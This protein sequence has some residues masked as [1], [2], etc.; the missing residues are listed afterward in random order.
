MYSKRISGYKIQ[1]TYRKQKKNQRLYCWLKE[2]QKFSSYI[3][4]QWGNDK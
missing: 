1:I 4:S 2:F 3:F